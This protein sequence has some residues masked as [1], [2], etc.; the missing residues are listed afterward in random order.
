MLYLSPSAKLLN[1]RINLKMDT[2]GHKSQYRLSLRSIAALVIVVFS[3]SAI[4]PPWPVYAQQPPSPLG[5][6]N[7]NLPLQEH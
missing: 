5:V 6:N 1:T 4:V 3:F 7:L 2:T